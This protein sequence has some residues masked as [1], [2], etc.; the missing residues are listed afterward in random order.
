MATTLLA[1]E[2]KSNLNGFHKTL[3]HFSFNK[4]FCS[5]PGFK[6][7]VLSDG[8]VLSGKRDTPVEIQG[9]QI[10]VLGFSLFF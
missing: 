9:I 6:R 10:D 8:V 4:I 3:I 5:H 7:M 2:N 1:S